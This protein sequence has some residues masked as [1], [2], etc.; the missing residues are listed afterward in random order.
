VADASAWRAADLDRDKSW[1]VTL[2]P[3]QI[4]EIDAALHACKARGLTLPRIGREDFPLPSLDPVLRRAVADLR[5][6]RGV[7]LLRGF[8]VAAY[9]MEDLQ[10]VF[11]GVGTHIGTGVTQNAR[12]EIV[13]HI[14]DLG[15]VKGRTR[16]FASTSE[17]KLHV[18]LSD[19]VGLM[20]IRPAKQ[21]GTSIASS[22]MSVFNAFL[23]E[24][25]E[26][27]P[28][29]FR[30]LP[31]DR[32]EE[33]GEGENAIG[34]V[35]PLFSEA[36]GKLSCRYNRRFIEVA[37]ERAGAPFA[38]NELRM[39]DLFDE[40]AGRRELAYR[41]RLEPGDMQFLNNYTVLHAREAYEDWPEHDRKRY[42]LRLWL[43]VDG[44]RP[45]VDEATVRFGVIRYGELGKPAA[46]LVAA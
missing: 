32:R 33:H 18:D 42:L 38:G 39:L 15:A 7:F 3:P 29:L 31:W 20:C 10:T 11:W 35:V 23:A 27:L 22:S 14:T 25:P 37:A 41:M 4:A 28:L 9:S 21:G 45:F 12:R 26:L 16:A 1:C 13:G 40:I 36:A 30:G 34:P 17:G 24:A 43:E 6:G 46:D 19:V 44:L 5:D 8:P 2:T